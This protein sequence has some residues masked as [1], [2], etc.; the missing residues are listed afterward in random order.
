MNE[1][2]DLVEILKDCPKGFKLYSSICGTVTFEGIDYHNSNYP[3]RVK[4]PT[5][6]ITFS[7]KGLYFYCYG[8]SECCLF[9][10]SEQRD[11][12]KFTAPWYKNEQASSQTNER[13]W[14][15]LVSDVLT[16]T[17]GIGQYLDNPEVQEIAKRL[18]SKYA[19]K[20]YSP[21]VLSNSSNMERTDKIDFSEALKLLKQGKTLRRDS[22]SGSKR[23]MLVNNNF[24]LPFIGIITKDG[25]MGVYTST[26]CDILAD[27]WIEI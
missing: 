26:N 8:D 13:T 27:D 17:H 9:P 2:I 23:I 7:K 10:S 4:T 20:L 21:S 15:Y 12:S 22:W 6:T 1:N 19:Q 5:T 11:W 18:C 24:L 16:W 25:S 14:L 3:I